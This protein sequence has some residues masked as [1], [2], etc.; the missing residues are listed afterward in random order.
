LPSADGGLA[1]FVCIFTTN[2]D[3]RSLNWLFEK[4]RHFDT[5]LLILRTG[6]GHRLGGFL[7]GSAWQPKGF[8]GSG[9]CFVFRAPP[10][11]GSAE[12]FS[13]N[14][15]AVPAARLAFAS[16][17]AMGFGGGDGFA[18]WI[19]AG[20]ETGASSACMAFCS[21]PLALEEGGLFEIVQ[22]DIYALVNSGL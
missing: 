13:W 11:P 2:L 6:T 10:L 5:S 1:R 18:V 7:A 3:G 12:T 15:N 14:S 19:D 16:P 9:E 21:P 17:D 4:T 22:L 20:L 8:V